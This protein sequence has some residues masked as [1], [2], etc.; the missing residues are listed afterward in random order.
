MSSRFGQGIAP[1]KER[2]HLEV[3][4]KGVKI[5]VSKVK[6]HPFASAMYLSC[7][8]ALLLLWPFP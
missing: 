4:T 2:L 7:I 3:K 6:V 5:E 8:L 1:E